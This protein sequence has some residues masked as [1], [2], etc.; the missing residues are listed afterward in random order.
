M[1]SSVTIS[2]GCRL[3]AV[4][5]VS[6]TGEIPRGDTGSSVN[7]TDDRGV[8]LQQ[9]SKALDTALVQFRDL[10][11]EFFR[12]AEGQLVSLSVEIA[13]KIL[14]QEIDS[15]R[16]R[17]D[18]IIT[19][20]MANVPACKDVEVH[21]HPADLA[22]CEQARESD[23]SSDSSH[24]RFLADENVRRAEC[25]LLAANGTVKADIETQLNDIEEALK[26]S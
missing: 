15:E 8:G 13:Q 14:M 5:V 19:E 16:Y 18:P 1:N 20:A 7:N 22:Q 24:V 25:V 11:D 23:E 4:E 12:Q 17:I 26:K 10:Q 9:A 2:L 3:R 6:A 21:L